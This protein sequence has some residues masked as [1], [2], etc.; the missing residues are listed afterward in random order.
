ML[1]KYIFSK[2]LLIILCFD[3]FFYLTINIPLQL[4]F[5]FTKFI[6]L[7]V[8]FLI[9]HKLISISREFLKYNAKNFTRID[10]SIS[11]IIKLNIYLSKY[12][13]V[14][15]LNKFLGLKIKNIDFKF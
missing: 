5:Y 12:L 7:L 13:Y 15:I 1:K 9:L 10:N 14:Q 4:V 6:L 8:F 3:N 11:L 2:R